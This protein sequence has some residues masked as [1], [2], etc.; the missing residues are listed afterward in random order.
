MVTS[1]TSIQPKKYELL[2][3]LSPKS[4][5]FCRYLI[6]KNDVT[7]PALKAAT[8]FAGYDVV[9][10]EYVRLMQ[11][12][13]ILEC[14]RRNGVDVTLRL[15]PLTEQQRCFVSHYM[16]NF[17]PK[18]AALEAGYSEKEDGSRL[19]RHPSVRKE[20]QDRQEELRDS[21]QISAARV[22][23]EYA[24]IGFADMGQFVTLGESNDGVFDMS[25][26]PLDQVDS[27]VISEISNGRYGPTIKLHS[28]LKAL[29]VLAKHL[30]LLRE[31]V[32]ITGKDGAELK[33]VSPAD[34]LLATLNKMQENQQK[35]DNDTTEVIEHDSVN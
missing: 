33:I 29:D 3:K 26:K 17:N 1:E 5:D 14:L 13:K 25:I 7:L 6:E 35:L 11:K 10:G 18:V 24:R 15:P 19:L 4:Q 34:N 12:P 23:M 20:I 16:E 32:E 9:K 31:R 2:G 28:K 27:A 30:G 21:S 22:L 8:E